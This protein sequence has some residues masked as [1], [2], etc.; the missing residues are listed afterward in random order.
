MRPAKFRLLPIVYL[1]LGL[2]LSLQVA[3]LA[4]CLHDDCH[5]ELASCPDPCSEYSVTSGPCCCTSIGYGCCSYT[6][7]YKGC[8]Y[9][10]RSPCGTVVV[11]VVNP[12]WPGN[13]HPGQNCVGNYCQQ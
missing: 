9:P 10:D 4:S 11:A 7:V 13:Q 3:A 8:V 2:A 5:G 6:C 1:T 12:A